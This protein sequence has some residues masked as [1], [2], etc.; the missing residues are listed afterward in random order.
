MALA[1]T[2]PLQAIV[3]G[4]QRAHHGGPLA[5]DLALGGTPLTVEQAYALQHRLLDALGEPGAFPRHW[6]SGAA[7]R[8]DV[9]KHAPLPSRG[10]RGSGASLADLPLRNRW[11]EA[12]VA[13]RIGR[14][15]PA[16]EAQQLQPAAV[17]GLVDGMCVSI[18]VLDSRWAGGRGAAP[19]LKLADLLM[20]GALVLGDFVPF[21]A[22]AWDQQA[23]H[24]AIGGA[25]EQRFRGSLGLGDP[26][27]VLP[28]WARHVTRQGASIPKGTVVSTGSWC[29]VLDAQRGDLVAVE[30]PGIGTA[31]ATL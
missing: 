17:P 27:W 21:S 7:S 20:H 10:V 1:D 11:I 19:L 8:A 15:V 14:D 13:L 12:E 9:L 23:C 18:E 24:I 2:D 3:E 30:F 16:A 22:R 26:T 29:G 5:D 31:A 6:K 4:L 25:G 28:A